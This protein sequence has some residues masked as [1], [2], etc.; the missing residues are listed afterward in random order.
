MRDSGNTHPNI[1][2]SRSEYDYQSLNL[3]KFEKWMELVVKEGLHEKVYI[4][5]ALFPPA[6][7]GLRLNMI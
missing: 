7:H 3:D 1:T 2:S 6:E 5:A 4:M